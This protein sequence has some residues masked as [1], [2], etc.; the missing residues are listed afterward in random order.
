MSKQCVKCKAKCCKYFSFEI[1]APDEYDEFEDIRWY[2]CHQDVTVHVDDG[3]WFIS[4]D[5]RCKWLGPDDRCINYEDR[6]IICRKYTQTTCDDSSDE[7]GYDQLF[8]KPEQLEAYARKTLGQAAFE[9]AR[10]K[11]RA[12]Y[13]PKK[14]AVTLAKTRKKSARVRKPGKK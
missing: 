11:F 4:I 1:D 13:E 6:P 2:L 9:Q 8:E 5:N 12:K 10:A 3:D 7:Y 14:P